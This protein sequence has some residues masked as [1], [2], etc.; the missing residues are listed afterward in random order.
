MYAVDENEVHETSP[1]GNLMIV[2]AEG[3]KFTDT[4]STVTE[5][6]VVSSGFRAFSFHM[7]PELLPT[8]NINLTATIGDYNSDTITV[9]NGPSVITITPTGVS[10]VIR[11]NSSFTMDFEFT[12]THVDDLTVKIDVFDVSADLVSCQKQS[13]KS[14]NLAATSF[15]AA[16]T[17]VVDGII[18]IPV[19][20]TDA[21]VFDSVANYA[22]TCEF[23][24]RAYV[25][26]NK[27]VS[28]PIH[29]IFDGDI[30]KTVDLTIP[31]IKRQL[32]SGTKVSGTVDRDSLYT[33]AEVTAILR[34]IS[35][36][37]Q[38]VDPTFDMLRFYQISQSLMSITVLDVSSSADTSL[39]FS[40]TVTGI[41]TTVIDSLADDAKTALETLG[42]VAQVSAESVTL[43]ADCVDGCVETDCGVCVDSRTCADE[44]DCLTSQCNNGKC[45][46]NSAASASAVIC[47]IIVAIVSMMLY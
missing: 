17:D 5:G 1:A 39:V 43:E 2:G 37:L 4:E 24:A 31:A 27:A 7:V 9:S 47:A 38:T 10:G 42:F 20:K 22:Y 29:V 3:L 16:I 6:L 21:T 15:I 35:T 44:S 46:G 34:I 25:K 11:E 40:T 19:S 14:T 45:G 32:V 12:A 18:S 30:V 23:T 41:S 28:V 8:I 36:V 26:G 33:P 13:V